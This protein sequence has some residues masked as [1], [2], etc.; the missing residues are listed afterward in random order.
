MDYFKPLIYIFISIWILIYRYLYFRFLHPENISNQEKLEQTVVDEQKQQELER[1]YRRALSTPPRDATVSNRSTPQ[2]IL[3]PISNVASPC[4]LRHQ[5]LSPQRLVDLQTTGSPILH[6]KVQQRSYT[7]QRTAAGLP[8]TGSKA[9]K[10]QLFKP[11]YKSSNPMSSPN[12]I[13]QENVISPSNI[14]SPPNTISPPNARSPP[15]AMTPPNIMSPPNLMSPP[16]NQYYS[17]QSM[18][19]S[20]NYYTPTLPQTYASGVE[21]TSTSVYETPAQMFSPNLEYNQSNLN[22]NEADMNMSQQYLQENKQYNERND[23]LLFHT[24]APDPSLQVYVHNEDYQRKQLQQLIQE[25]LRLEEKMMLAKRREGRAQSKTQERML[26]TESKLE[27]IESKL[28]QESRQEHILTNNNNEINSFVVSKN[29]VMKKQTSSKTETLV[30]NGCNLVS[31]KVTQV[32]RNSSEHRSERQMEST[33]V[34]NTNSSTNM[35]ERIKQ[36]A[37]D[38]IAD[39]QKN[40]FDSRCL[41]ESEKDKLRE[42]NRIRDEEIRKMQEH[43]LDEKQKRSTAK[44]ACSPGSSD[45]KKKQSELRRVKTDDKH[46]KK[47]N[48]SI[49]KVIKNNQLNPETS[50]DAVSSKPFKLV[51]AE[52]LI[53][54][55]KKK[56]ETNMTHDRAAKQGAGTTENSSID[57]ETAG[58]DIVKE[59]KRKVDLKRLQEQFKRDQILIQEEM[60]KNELKAKE[61]H[62]KRT[63]DEAKRMIQLEEENKNEER[64]IFENLI[65]EEE[66]KLLEQKRKLEEKIKREEYERNEEIRKIEVQK[67]ID[68]ERQNEQRSMEQRKMIQQN[69]SG[70]NNFQINE[71][72]TGARKKSKSNRSIQASYESSKLKVYEQK[73]AELQ[74][75]V[76]LQYTEAARKLKEKLHKHQSNECQAE[77]NI[78]EDVGVEANIEDKLDYLRQEEQQQMK[79]EAKLYDYKRHLENKRSLQMEDSDDYASEWDESSEISNLEQQYK[80]GGNNELQHEEP[81]DEL[82]ATSEEELLQAQEKSIRNLERQIRKQKEKHR[83]RSTSTQKQSHNLPKLPKGSENNSARKRQLKESHHRQRQYASTGDLTRSNSKTLPVTKFSPDPMEFGFKPIE[84][85]IFSKSLSNLEMGGSVAAG[86]AVAGA[87]AGAKATADVE[88]ATQ[89]QDVRCRSEVLAKTQSISA[90]LGDLQQVSLLYYGRVSRNLDRFDHIQTA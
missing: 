52:Q 39:F 6:P 2:R 42:E 25:K 70:A 8:V 81:F 11:E 24:N 26:T 23:D 74:K 54:Q 71:E 10:Q 22:T 69:T 60:K 49:D 34:E 89:S 68:R 36:T 57:G 61:N 28:N 84:S 80:E 44:S 30:R 53:E 32:E 45:L 37:R 77:S 33:T 55:N 13:Y 16:F 64:K 38:K 4:P 41:D 14:C 48:Q 20:E 9:F 5:I 85:P 46:I 51:S 88:E 12:T 31:R 63:E 90:S 62:R 78:Y 76:Q 40:S 15:Y 21:D 50:F 59:N 47:I 73:R 35:I 29:E 86:A 67:K 19:G 18:T 82:R 3:S 56:R 43:N 87:Q 75:V 7:A 72:N 79:E 58:K 1:K 83:H 17:N 66:Q 65:I 27:N